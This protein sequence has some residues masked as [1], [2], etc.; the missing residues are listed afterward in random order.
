MN[1][2]VA[3]LGA[4]LDTATSVLNELAERSPDQ[5][6]PLL[7]FVRRMVELGFNSDQVIGLVD[8][9]IRSNK[10]SLNNRYHLRVYT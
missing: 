9:L 8:E 2:P 7:Q 6:V 4:D 3:T 5:E 10:V 1:G